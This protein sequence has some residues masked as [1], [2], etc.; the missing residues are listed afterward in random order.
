MTW[1]HR[2]PTELEWEEARHAADGM[3]QSL[4]ELG[5]MTPGPKDGPTF[6][7][8]RLEE[9]RVFLVHIMRRNNATPS[10]RALKEL[11]Q[12]DLGPIKHLSINWR[13]WPDGCPACMEPE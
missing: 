2:G 12:W 7:Q 8:L 13:E 3:Y 6:R 9:A 4:D 10:K 5:G 11:K 1:K